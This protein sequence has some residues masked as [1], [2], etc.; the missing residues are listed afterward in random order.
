MG[1]N[2]TLIAESP[3]ASNDSDA[4]IPRRQNTAGSHQILIAEPY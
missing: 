4:S 3:F 1:E 2:G